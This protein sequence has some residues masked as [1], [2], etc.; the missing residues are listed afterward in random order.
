L[1]KDEWIGWVGAGNPKKAALI[2][3]DKKVSTGWRQG[4]QTEAM[5]GK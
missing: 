1:L 3:F 5:T 2:R 4:W